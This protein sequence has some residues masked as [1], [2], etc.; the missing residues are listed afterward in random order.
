MEL[1][2]F[3]SSQSQ[4][5]IEFFT[6]VFSASEGET[7]GQLIGSLVSDL[8]TMTKPQDLIGFV[9]VSGNVIVGREIREAIDAHRTFA[10]DIKKCPTVGTIVWSND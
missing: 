3:D 5:V 8:I 10:K 9:A 4:E 1:S 6:K 7:E 2:L